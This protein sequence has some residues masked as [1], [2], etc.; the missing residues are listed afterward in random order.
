FPSLLR[1]EAEAACLSDSDDTLHRLP[2]QPCRIL[3]ENRYFLD[4]CAIIWF[5]K[6]CSV[7]CCFLLD[8]LVS[9]KRAIVIFWIQVLLTVYAPFPQDFEPP[10]ACNASKSIQTP[11]RARYPA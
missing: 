5:K 11:S 3:R 9:F 10:L 4:G 2:E 6:A 8:S 7:S 1:S